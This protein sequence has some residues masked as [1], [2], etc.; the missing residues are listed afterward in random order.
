MSC[1]DD[2]ITS[3]DRD[4]EDGESKTL[5]EIEVIVKVKEEHFIPE[6]ANIFV[7]MPSRNDHPA[8]MEH[9]KTVDANNLIIDKVTEKASAP[10][11]CSGVKKLWERINKRI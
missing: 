4:E 7:R 2:Y 8:R 3:S 9:S 6:T 10:T 5:T 1:D 11:G